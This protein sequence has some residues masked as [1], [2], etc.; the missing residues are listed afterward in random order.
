MLLYRFHHHQ[1]HADSNYFR[2]GVTEIVLSPTTV[3]AP[4][5][6]LTFVT[7]G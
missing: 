2:E 7:P 6:E 4:V 1:A 5:I 3:T